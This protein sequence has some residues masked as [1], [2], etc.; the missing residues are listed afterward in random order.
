M[1]SQDVKYIHV[2]VETALRKVHLHVN[3]HVTN[4]QF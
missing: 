3:I 2:V 4:N 1:W